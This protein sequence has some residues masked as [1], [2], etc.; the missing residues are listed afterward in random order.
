RL[1]PPVL[2]R[3]QPGPEEG[4]PGRER[5]GHRPAHLLRSEPA[6]AA[7]G[8]ARRCLD[9]ARRLRA[10]VLRHEPGGA[11][12][13][14]QHRRGAGDDRGVPRRAGH[15]HAHGHRAGHRPAQVEGGHA[16]VAVR[17]RGPEAGPVPAQGDGPGAEGVPVLADRLGGPAGAAPSE[18]REVRLLR[19]P[20]PARQLLVLGAGAGRRQPEPDP[21]RRDLPGGAAPRA[22]PVPALPAP[23]GVPAPGTVGAVAPALH[24]P[25][26]GDPGRL[27]RAAE[28]L[29]AQRRGAVGGDR[30]PH[31]LHHPRLG[32]RRGAGRPARGGAGHPPGGPRRRRPPRLAADPARPEAGDLRT[33]RPL[34]WY[35]WALSLTHSA[36]PPPRSAPPRT[37]PAATGSSTRPPWAARRSRGAPTSPSGCSAR[38]ASRRR[39]RP[40]ATPRRWSGAGA[41]SSRCRS[42]A[43]W[44]ATTSTARP[45]ASATSASWS[46]WTWRPAR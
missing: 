11:A 18:V 34:Q 22:R 16:L 35:P 39:S 12:P 1:G 20:G 21:V 31:R 41:R 10:V 14:R 5:H 30:G 33:C 43:T 3:Q 37:P 46:R 29:A 4:G 19:G 40:G 44:S 15:L 23:L 2:Q 24:G 28:G 36:L 27:R 9:G 7:P 25:E 38:W 13:R 6:A 42:P 17:H 8:P 32:H 26:L 45:P